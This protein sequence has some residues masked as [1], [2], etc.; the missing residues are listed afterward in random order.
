MVKEIRDYA[1]YIKNDRDAVLRACQTYA[2]I[3]APRGTDP[4]QTENS[5]QF[6]SHL[7]YR[8]VGRFMQ[9]GYKFC[10]WYDMVWME[11]HIGEHTDSLPPRPCP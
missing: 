5:I 4:F 7:G 3:S 8:L 9:C 11:K 1:D 10:R 2:C 6:H